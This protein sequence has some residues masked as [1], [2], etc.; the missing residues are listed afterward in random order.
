MG[1]LK[2]TLK[3]YPYDDP[4]ESEDFICENGFVSRVV[5]S[6][7]HD[8]IGDAFKVCDILNAHAKREGDARPG[9]CCRAHGALEALMTRDDFWNQVQSSTI[10][11]PGEYDD[12]TD[13][14]T[15]ARQVARGM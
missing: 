10:V 4:K 3:I 1:T 12:C 8:N 13:A 11:I 5:S 2:H 9:S 7:A 6:V 15:H 14:L